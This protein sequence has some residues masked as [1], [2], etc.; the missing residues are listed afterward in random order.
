MGVPL[1]VAFVAKSGSRTPERELHL[2]RVMEWNKGVMLSRGRS[3][4]QGAL[5][6]ARWRSECKPAVMTTV[7]LVSPN[8]IKT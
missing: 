3:G 6:N 4:S 2:T 5:G 7:A 1:S 8:Y